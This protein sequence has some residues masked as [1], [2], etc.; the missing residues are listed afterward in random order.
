MIVALR[1]LIVGA[2]VLYKKSIINEK[3][4]LYKKNFVEKNV[5]FVKKLLTIV[6]ET[7]ILIKQFKF[8]TGS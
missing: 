7:F 5:F 4:F 8:C 1:F 6:T 2:T 3:Y